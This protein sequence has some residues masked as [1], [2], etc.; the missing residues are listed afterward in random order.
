M[1]LEPGSLAFFDG[2][3]SGISNGKSYY[4]KEDLILEM[5]LHLR[6][7]EPVF[8]RYFSAGNV[9]E[10]YGYPFGTRIDLAAAAKSCRLLVAPGPQAKSTQP[11]GG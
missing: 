5:L 3:L 8:A 7:R 9:L 1:A 10:D 4:L 11:V 2:M 6:R